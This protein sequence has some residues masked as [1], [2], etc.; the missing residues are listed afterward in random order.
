MTGSVV[1]GGDVVD[2]SQ[3]GT[4]TVT[5]DVIDAAGNAADQ[6]TRTVNVTAGGGGGGGSDAVVIDR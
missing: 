4:Y 1:V 6:V 2:L 5:Y 3:A